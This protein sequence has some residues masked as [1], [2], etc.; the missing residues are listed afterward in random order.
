[1]AIIRDDD[2]FSTEIFL[3]TDLKEFKKQI[4]DL[5]VT[6]LENETIYIC[7]V[8]EIIH[9]IDDGTYIDEEDPEDYDWCC[10]D[11]GEPLEYLPAIG[12]FACTECQRYYFREQLE[13]EQH[14]G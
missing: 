3:F 1:M 13:Q 2:G 8:R 10:L 7:D 14:I 9:I 4:D 12:V 5:V 11:D 6:S